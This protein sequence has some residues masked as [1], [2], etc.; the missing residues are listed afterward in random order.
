MYTMR[1]RPITYEVDEKGCH[2]CTS[3]KPTS[4][5]YPHMMQAGV[6]SNV[7]RVVY[8]FERGKIPGGFCVCHTCDNRMCINPAHLFLGT[9]KDNAHDCI[10]KGRKALLY[11][12][13][14]GS[15]KLTESQVIQIVNDL[16]TMT[17]SQISRDRNIPV[18]TINDIK[19]GTQWG[20]LT[21]IK[22]GY[23]Q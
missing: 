18:R 8:T 10:I 15:H 17:C 23:V 20:W 19:I 6:I 11:G 2:I 5:G 3:H 22:P 12:E 21:G 4:N 1:T 7:S 16:K 9:H 13:R 14:N